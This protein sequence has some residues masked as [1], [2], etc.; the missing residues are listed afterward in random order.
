MTVEDQPRVSPQQRI[1]CWNRL[2]AV[3]R[4]LAGLRRHDF[5]AA[6]TWAHMRFADSPRVARWYRFLIWSLRQM[7]STIP[8]ALTDVTWNHPISRVPFWLAAGNPWE[9]HPWQ[10]QPAA[11]LPERVDTVVI[12]CG[13]TGAA[14]AYHWSRGAPTDRRL[15]VLE[16]DDPASGS[17]GRNEGLVVMGRYYA[18]VRQTVLPYLTRVRSELTPAECERLADQFASV[19][20]AAAYKNADL[21]EQTIRREGIDCDYR[22]EG[23]VQATDRKGQSSLQESVG[24][25]RESGFTD[26]TSITPE[27]V[28]QRC[29]MQVRHNA[30]FSIAAAS[31]HPARWVWGLLDAALKTPHVRLFTRTPVRSIVR[32][33][34]DYYVETAR[35][36]LVARHVIN[37]TES[38][39]PLLHPELHNVIQPTQTQA[40]M[41]TGGPE[42][43]PAGVGISGPS[44][45]CGRHGEHVMLGSDAT[46]VPDHEAGRIQ[47]S[48]FLTK[49]LLSQLQQHF[50]AFRMRM[51]HEWSG[52]VGYTPDEFPVVGLLDDHAQF[53]I[54]GMAGSGTA[55]SFNAAR[56]ICARIL[57]TAGVDDDYPPEYFAPSR[58][59]HPETHSWPQIASSSGVGLDI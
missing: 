58:L 36:R 32:S 21:V 42:S 44:F 23:W 27:S 26:W 57:G 38:Y 12:G 39:T 4:L 18:Y 17:S 31:F 51:T 6:R 53:V 1:S 56:C 16:M 50:G 10:D 45:F 5:R 9:N 28:R 54:G 34:A 29:G 14:A 25:A 52:T 24:L 20:C 8:D 33:G 15:A 3:G 19:Y 41:G 7:W 2:R 46:R 59:Q 47:P 11:E 30:G 37:A 43:V 13:F 48:R 22:R 40:A 35:G 49:Y 55:V